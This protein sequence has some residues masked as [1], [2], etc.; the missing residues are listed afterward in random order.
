MLPPHGV[1]QSEVLAQQ[2]S[3][4][5]SIESADRLPGRSVRILGPRD[6]RDPFGKH[7]HS[8]GVDA[9]GF[10]PFL[11]ERV[12]FDRF[13]PMPELPEV[14]HL[15]RTLLPHLTGAVV[16]D[17]VLHRVDVLQAVRPSSGTPPS[18]APL[19][20]AV[21]SEVRRRGKQLAVVTDR[22]TLGVQLG[23]SGALRIT[24]GETLLPPETAHSE[25]VHAQFRVTTAGG[26]QVR[27]EFRDPRRFGGLW[28]AP[29]LESF[30]EARW[31]MLGPDALDLDDA[32]FLERFTHRPRMLKALLLDQATIAGVG[33]IYADEALFA[34]RLHPA[35][36]AAGL[37][38]DRLRELA[39]HLRD[40][41]NRAIENR[42]SSIRSYVDADG[43]AGDFALRH[44]VY[45][46]AEQP[47]VVCGGVLR[48]SQ[49]AGRTTVHCPRCQAKPRRPARRGS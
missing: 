4:A 10:R 17:A 44:A 13:A 20:G 2:T 3:T 11:V 46:R 23:M 24:A 15:R 5:A 45:G 36:P 31:R 25:H 16:G 27:L 47:C 32:R 6:D 43:N 22:G 29:T 1:G 7:R 9:A 40:I 8:T 28:I 41:L 37:S 34:A 26:A 35:R 30:I 39:R 14:E 18:L 21:V 49:V 33:N 38:G 48:A 12:L 19:Q 42:G